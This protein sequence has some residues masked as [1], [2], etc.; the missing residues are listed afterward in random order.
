MQFPGTDIELLERATSGDEDALCQL[1]EIVGADVRRQLV[2]SP[3]WNG[4]IEVDDV[5]QITYLEAFL[6][7]LDFKPMTM[8]AFTGWLRRIAQNNLRDAVDALSAEKR[9]QNRVRPASLEDSCFQFFDKMVGTTTTPSRSASRREI[10]QTVLSALEK[11]PP[12]Y[13]KVL[14]LFDL[15][16]KSGQEVA[17][18][19]GRSP[20]AVRMLLA[21]ARDRLRELL[22]SS[23]ALF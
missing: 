15:E 23:S 18:E 6:R 19:I 8:A 21:R 13:A 2:I 1:L 10:Q 3:K 20:G 5:M 4:Q 12:D 22:T 16:G 11:L 14:R 17:A 9:P 7:I